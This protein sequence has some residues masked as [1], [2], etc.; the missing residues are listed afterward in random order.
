MLGRLST[1]AAQPVN[2]TAAVIYKRVPTRPVSNHHDT[3]GIGLS[4]RESDQLSPCDQELEIN[5]KGLISHRC[6]R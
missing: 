3:Q 2:S 5:T 1:G 4:P 6:V